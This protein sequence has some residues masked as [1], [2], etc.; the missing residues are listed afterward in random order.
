[1]TIEQ[2]QAQKVMLSS[3]LGITGC[4]FFAPSMTIRSL[5]LLLSIALTFGAFGQNEHFDWLGVDIMPLPTDSIDPVPYSGEL[6]TFDGGYAVGDTIGDFRLWSLDGD[7]FIL[8]NEI[9]PEKPTIIFNGSATCIRFQNDWDINQPNNIVA[10][11]NSHLDDFNWIP[12]YVAE[13]H[14]LDLENCP[15]NCPA[16]PIAGPDGQYLN[17][18]RIVQDRHDAAQTVIDYMGPGSDNGWAFPWDDMLIDTPGNIIYENFFLRPAGMVVVNCNGVVVERANWLGLF[19]GEFN[20]QMAL[21]G[22][23]QEPTNID[24]PCLLASNAEEICEEGAPDSDGDGTCDALELEMG[25][26]PFNPCDLGI[27]GQEDSDQDGACDAMELLSGTDPENPCDPFYLDSDNDGFCDIEEAI[28]G[29]NPNNPCSPSTVDTDGD[30]YCDSEEIDMGSDLN[31]PC[32]PDLLDSDMDGICNSSELANGTDPNNTCDPLG[33]DTDGDGLCDQLESV[34]GSSQNDP[35]SPYSED[36]D[37]D[38]FCDQLESIESW[39]ASDACIPNDTDLDGDGW[40]SGMEFASGWSDA[41]P[42]LPIATDS[43]GDGLC[44]MEELL[45][46]HDPMD[47]CSPAILDTDGDGLC[48]MYEVLNGSSPFAAEAVLSTGS[49]NANGLMVLPSSAG[50]EVS[51]DACLGKSWLLLDAAGRTMNSGT[52]ASWNAWNAPKGVYVLSLPSLGF[53]SRVV[54]QN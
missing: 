33:I 30:G 11:V 42:C 36:S 40:C 26:D 34:I 54:V 9:D 38:G 48:D 35:C 53:H 29:S 17:Q 19:L 7:D 51:C 16:L 31:D 32:S 2:R 28:L 1:M 39:D 49:L 20:N 12:V 37:G 3:N 43:D 5:S 6:N 21:E 52:L 24:G 22:L 14:A 47:P 23:I 45:L 44:D 10:W 4:V 15:S 18:H 46:G 41:D 50:F 27:E 25:T 13:A 8:S